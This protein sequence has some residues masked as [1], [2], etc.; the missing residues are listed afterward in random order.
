MLIL[1]QKFADCAIELTISLK[2]RQGHHTCV[3]NIVLRPFDRHSRLL[4]TTH[5][6]LTTRVC[7][8]PAQKG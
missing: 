7:P 8:A 4:Q 2:A 1:R 3:R 6:W 5:A